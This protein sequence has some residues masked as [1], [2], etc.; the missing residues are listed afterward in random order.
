MPTTP[1]SLNAPAL[2]TPRAVT[3]ADTSDH[4]NL[5]IVNDAFLRM[6]ARRVP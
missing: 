3:A 4:G 1:L 2:K 5:G 6:G